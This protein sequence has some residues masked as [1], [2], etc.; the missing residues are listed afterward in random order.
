MSNIIYL[1]DYRNEEELPEPDW[2]ELKRLLCEA[3][4]WLD[5]EDGHDCYDQCPFLASESVSLCLAMLSQVEFKTGDDLAKH[6][7]MHVDWLAFWMQAM[8]DDEKLKE[9]IKELCENVST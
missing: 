7:L 2:E 4:E 8:P 6:F 1:D 3:E 9:R 5:S